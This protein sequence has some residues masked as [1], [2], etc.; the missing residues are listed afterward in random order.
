MPYILASQHPLIHATFLGTHAVIWW[1]RDMNTVTHDEDEIERARVF[2]IISHTLCLI[3]HL[4]YRMLE[5]T[6]KPVNES[7]KQA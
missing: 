1:R 3:L 4:I 6:D 7:E 2:M 5:L